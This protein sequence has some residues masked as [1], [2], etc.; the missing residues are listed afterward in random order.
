M[1]LE[2]WGK[3]RTEEAGDSGGI[4]REMQPEKTPFG[5]QG[6][7]TIE[8]MRQMALEIVID[9]ARTAQIEEDMAQKMIAR[10]EEMNEAELRQFFRAFGEETDGGGVPLQGRA[11][12]GM[13]PQGMGQQG[14]GQQ[15]T[16]QFGLG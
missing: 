14:M 16:P 11:Q 4:I 6:E 10:I 9:F 8:G 13:A 15:R 2:M 7:N 12:Q 3:G 1:S 5:I